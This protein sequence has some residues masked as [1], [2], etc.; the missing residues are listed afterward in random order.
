MSAYGNHQLYRIIAAYVDAGRKHPAG[1][2][3]CRSGRMCRS[4][5]VRPLF[6][7]SRLA[8][9]APTRRSGGRLGPFSLFRLFEQLLTPDRRDPA[10]AATFRPMPGPARYATVNA[11][12]CSS[13]HF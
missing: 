5:C 4:R 13:A 6:T 8:A 12:G 11:A 7:R 2:P 3:P 9:K 10:G 1:Y